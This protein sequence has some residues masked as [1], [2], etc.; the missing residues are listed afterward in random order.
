MLF[1][2][3]LII[4]RPPSTIMFVH[5]DNFIMFNLFVSFTWSSSSSRLIFNLFNFCW[6]I[7]QS[8]STKFNL[9]IIVIFV[10]DTKPACLYTCLPL[11]AYLPL[12]A[13]LSVCLP[14]CLPASV[15]V[16][17][18]QWCLF[19]DDIYHHRHLLI[20]LHRLNRQIYH[21][22]H[23][24]SRK[25]RLI[26]QQIYY[27]YKSNITVCVSFAIMTYDITTAKLTIITI[28]FFAMIAIIASFVVIA[29]FAFTVLN[30]R[31]HP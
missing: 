7:S 29:K 31:H 17:Q 22:C 19:I 8:S 27:R 1:F 16:D 4:R 24:L 12:P 9:L 26:C 20:R 10:F 11:P 3:C 2:T 25:L 23:C 21:H 5:Q 15:N 6:Q 18:F 28:G 14:V 13:C 30:I